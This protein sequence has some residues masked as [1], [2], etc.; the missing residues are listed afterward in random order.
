MSTDQVCRPPSKISGK[1]PV[2]KKMPVP[3]FE[4]L[5]QLPKW[6]DSSVRDRILGGGW[7]YGRLGEW[8][9]PAL[10]SL[11]TIAALLCPG[12]ELLSVVRG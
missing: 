4:A 11:A 12:L 9:S 7:C 5:F 3:L 10:P 1:M 6:N 2:Q 8:L